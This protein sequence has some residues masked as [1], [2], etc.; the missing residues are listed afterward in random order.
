MTTM[1]MATAMTRRRP[2]RRDG[3]RTGR[4]PPRL[5]RSTTTTTTTT[6]HRRNAQRRTYVVHDVAGNATTLW[7]TSAS[8]SRAGGA[9]GLGLRYND[10][11]DEDARDQRPEVRLDDEQQSGALAALLS[12]EA[13]IGTRPAPSRNGCG[14]RRAPQRDRDR[15]GPQ[16]ETTAT[17]TAM[18]TATR[19][20]LARDAA[21]PRAPADPDGEGHA[22]DRP[23]SLERRAVARAGHLSLVGRQSRSVLAALL[24]LSWRAPRPAAGPDGAGPRPARPCMSRELLEGAA[25]D[26]PGAGLT[27]TRT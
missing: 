23:V 20:W 11:E 27:F 4:G 7:W 2:R 21:R 22:G 14:L 9:A 16:V 10:G 24:A 15:V 5:A 26:A 8:R 3:T 19:T 18:T 12:Q 1:T 6:A 25:A 13:R 17:T